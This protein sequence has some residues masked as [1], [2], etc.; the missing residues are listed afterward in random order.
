MSKCSKANV[1]TTIPNE[2][3]CPPR[4]FI[5]VETCFIV[6]NV[7]GPLTTSVIS[8]P[9][10]QGTF[11]SA[12][13]FNSNTSTNTVQ[14]GGNLQGDSTVYAVQIPPGSSGTL[15]LPNAVSMNL[16]APLNSITSG[17][18]CIKLYVI[19]RL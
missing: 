2:F 15:T 11:V 13:F 19:Q 8:G 7:Q 4:T 14:L 3:C 10:F 18:V 6:E 16:S 5:P 17:R 12:T 9:S 1:L